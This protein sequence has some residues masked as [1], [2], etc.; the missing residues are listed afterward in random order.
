MKRHCGSDALVTI[1][2]IKATRGVPYL[3]I[4]VSMNERCSTYP[5]GMKLRLYSVESDVDHLATFTVPE[6]MRYIANSN[7]R[8]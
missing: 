2:S 8:P 4:F 3:S 7:L 5:E 1:D 6:L